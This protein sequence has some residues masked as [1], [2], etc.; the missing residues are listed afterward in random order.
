[1]SIKFHGTHKVLLESKSTNQAHIRVGLFFLP[2]NE[3]TPYVTWLINDQFDP[4]ATVTGN[5]FR[6]LEDAL[7]DYKKRR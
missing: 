3:N 4:P 5:Y 2:N 7:K 6:D 1:M